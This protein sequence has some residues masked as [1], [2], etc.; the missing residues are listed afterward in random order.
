MGSIAGPAMSHV[1]LRQRRHE[2][3]RCL[4]VVTMSATDATRHVLCC[5][6]VAV[7]SARHRKVRHPAGMRALVD[8][9]SASVLSAAEQKTNLEQMALQCCDI[10]YGH[11][12][13]AILA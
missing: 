2:R 13:Q 9:I 6:S 11:T 1:V 5:S 3:R 4:R 12:A 10:W 8:V 7:A